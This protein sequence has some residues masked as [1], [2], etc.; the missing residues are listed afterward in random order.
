M[1]RLI[2]WFFL[3]SV[4]GIGN[5]L[6]KRLIDLLGSPENVLD[7]PR[8][9]LLAVEGMTDRLVG[10][11]R[12][13]RMPDKVKRDIDLTLQ[14]GYGIVTQADAVYPPLLRQIP[15]PPPFL[16]VYGRLDASIRNIAVV[17]SRNATNYGLTTAKRLCANLAAMDMTIVSGMALGIDTAAHEGA[18]TA[19]RRTIAVLGSGLGVVYPARNRQLF[20]RIGEN[21]TVVSE[22]PML[23]PP[24]AHHFP[25]RNRVISGM[26]LGTVVVEA[27]RRSGSLITARLAAEQNREVFAIPG[28]IQSFKSTGTHT[29]IKQGAKLVEQAMDI[30]EELSHVVKPRVKGDSRGKQAKG[31]QTPLLSPE[32][33]P[34]Y[35]ALG[36]YPVHIDELVRKLAMPPGKLSGILLQLELRGIVHQAPGNLFSLKDP[37]G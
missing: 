5:H 18:L 12:R 26:S 8:P 34:V 11:I 21:G 4:P 20:H 17:G 37:D 19:D 24:D 27:T 23:A 35:N 25:M 30:M 15:D 7:A 28:S 2:P 1:E 16:Y 33:R 32:E 14:K 13:H 22:F 3:K 9:A 10:A 6:F 31:H 36:P 29:L